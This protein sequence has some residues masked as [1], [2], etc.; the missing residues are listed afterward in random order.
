MIVERYLKA[1]YGYNNPLDR[2]RANALI[3]LNWVAA[4]TWAVLVIGLVIPAA[5]QNTLH[6]R[7]IVIALVAPGVF[8]LIYRFVNVG[9]L[10]W[11]A[12]SFIGLAV[13]VTIPGERVTALS[14][15]LAALPII[16]SGVLTNRLGMFIAAL[17]V[18]GA[19][20]FGFVT[21]PLAVEL[22]PNNIVQYS[23]LL[24]FMAV[25]LAIFNSNTG[26]FVSTSTIDLEE[27]RQI[28]RFNAETSVLENEN[29][30]LSRTINIVR[31]QL[32]YNYAQIYL[33]DEQ[34]N[35]AQRVRTGLGVELVSVRQ[36]F[37][38]GDANI[39]SEAART[40]QIVA[41]SRVDDERRHGHLLPGVNYGIAVPI[42]YRDTIL[43]VLDVQRETQSFNESQ[44]A[45][46]NLLAQQIGAQ[47]VQ[48]REL[49]A[50]RRS[51]YEQEATADNL[52]RQLQEL[53]HAGRES[54]GSAWNS[55]LQQ[56]GQE[57]IGFDLPEQGGTL[58]LATELSPELQAAMTRG[59]IYQES[60]ADGY[61]VSVPINLR[62]QVLGAMSF[63]LP[64]DR[65]LSDRQIEMMQNVSDRLALS[66]ET[67]RLFEQS[68]AQALRE[69]K[70]SET[71][72]LLIS[73]TDVRAVL[74]LAAESFNR[75]LGA[76]NT[77]IYLQPSFLSE[78]QGEQPNGQG[79]ETAL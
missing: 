70:A 16:A 50:V 44:M 3:V 66:L 26:Q 30:I 20:G 37:N 63:R 10:N 45:A 58:R 68:Q 54:S 8:Y 21:Q 7:A 56:K 47:L 57:L 74:N 1:Q 49:E 33:L 72:N 35:L 25:L 64:K 29:A 14:F 4:I 77:H 5:V 32:G 65:P 13:L 27:I 41:V 55:Y 38:I 60:D 53:R 19:L 73:A 24:V 67:K 42:L 34:G 28:T 36:D 22:S 62:G 17:L 46:L 51:L 59:G 6:V 9:R 23:A 75:A 12:W 31:D 71:A 18:A 2:Q 43:G 78:Q 39:I 79:K 52:R 76:I 11:A 61:T 40:Q 69:R 15:L 48:R